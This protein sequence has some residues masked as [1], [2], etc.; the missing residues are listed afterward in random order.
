MPIVYTPRLALREMTD[1]DADFMLELL[2]DASFLRY[3]GDRGVRTIDGAREYIRKGPV[4]SYRRNGFG[5]YIVEVKG[6]G[7]VIGTCGLVRREG[8]DDVDIGFAFLPQYRT[9]GYATE[10]ATAILQQAREQLG[11]TRIVA[12]VSPDNERSAN[13][14][15]KIGL[16]FERMIRL[17]AN[18]PEIELYAWE[19]TE[20]EA[21]E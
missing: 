4:A 20:K 8:L 2:N 19:A 14:L 10:A 16:K 18:E 3:I 7:E 9:Q 17:T 5:L 6:T 21:A 12:I 15:R 1:E 11:F 13:V